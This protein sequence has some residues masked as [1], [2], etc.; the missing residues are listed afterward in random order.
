VNSIIKARKKPVIIEAIQ[1]TAFYDDATHHT[2]YGNTNEIKDWI[3]KINRAHQPRI[4]TD[5]SGEFCLVIPTLEGDHYASYGDY[6]IR[7]VRDEFYPCKKAIFEET[8][9]VVSE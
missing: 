8:Y 1:W 7:G 2:D 6:I 9:E 4:D 5:P 3:W